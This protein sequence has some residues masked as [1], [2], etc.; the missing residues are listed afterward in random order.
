LPSSLT[1]VFLLW[2]LLTGEIYLYWYYRGRGPEPVTNW[3]FLAQMYISVMWALYAV[4]LMVIGFWRK[5]VTLRYIALGLFTLALLK[6]FTY[7]M[8][9]VESVYRIAGFIVLGGA[10]IA[11]SFLYQYCKKKGFFEPQSLERSKDKD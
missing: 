5:V 1:A 11:V 4:A 9:A 8:S 6:V 2:V 7:D 10:L 3:E